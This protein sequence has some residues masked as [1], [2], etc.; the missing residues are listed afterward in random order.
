MDLACL[1]HQLEIPGHWH[2]ASVVR[3]VN[4]HGEIVSLCLMPFDELDDEEY[5]S[6]IAGS[7]QVALLCLVLDSLF[8]VVRLAMEDVTFKHFPD[9]IQIITDIITHI[10]RGKSP[11]PKHYISL[12]GHYMVWLMLHQDLDRDPD[13]STLGA[14]GVA[15]L[16]NLRTCTPE[17]EET[18][19]YRH[20]IEDQTF[21]SKVVLVSRF[22]ISLWTTTAEQKHLAV[23]QP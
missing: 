3:T 23:L 6:A 7:W 15:L 5:E 2:Y 4:N 14:R 8:T 21:L 1:G 22:P 10:F 9:C 20:L 12:L 13:T 18:D 19:V 17:E 11:F 16:A